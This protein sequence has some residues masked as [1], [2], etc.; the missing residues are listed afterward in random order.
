MPSPYSIDP[1]GL[2]GL[3][4][5]RLLAPYD[6]DALRRIL[7]T[8]TVKVVNRC[9]LRALNGNYLMVNTCLHTDDVSKILPIVCRLVI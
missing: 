8:M 3:L 9:S 1:T 6:I 5:H 4:N 2:S 7:H